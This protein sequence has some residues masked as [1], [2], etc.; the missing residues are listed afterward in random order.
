MKR[1]IFFISIIAFSCGNIFAQTKK[2]EQKYHYSVDEITEYLNGSIKK[3]SVTSY[4][5]KIDANGIITPNLESDLDY[6]QYTVWYEEGENTGTSDLG[7]NSGGAYKFASKFNE[8][9]LIEKMIYYGFGDTI[10]IV[11]CEYDENN[12]R[13]LEKNYSPDMKTLEFCERYEYDDDGQVVLIK[14]YAPNGE[15]LH[16]QVFAY[17]EKGNIVAMHYYTYNEGELETLSKETYFYI[18]DD[19]DNWIWKYIYWED[20]LEWIA[21]RKITYY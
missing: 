20:N 4:P 17:N 1:T 6:Y 5:P 7:R 14:S 3:V 16:K 19:S 8:D 11:L 15:V 2:N 21:V 13:V 12:N 9:G 10:N 18:Y